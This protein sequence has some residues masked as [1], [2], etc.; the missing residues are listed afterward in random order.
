MILAVWPSPTLLLLKFLKKIK[1]DKA[2][3]VLIGMVPGPDLSVILA[4]SSHVIYDRF[5]DSRLRENYSIQSP[6]ATL[7]DLAAEWLL[8]IEIDCSF[9]MQK[10]LC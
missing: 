5:A 4:I 3:Q 2:I 7:Q 6:Q 8:V 9:E 10:I 1:Q